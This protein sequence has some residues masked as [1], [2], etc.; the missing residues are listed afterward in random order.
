MVIDE[1]NLDLL[2][3]DMHAMLSGL[4][5]LIICT[6]FVSVIEC[7]FESIATDYPRKL[8][9]IASFDE[10]C[11]KIHVSFQVIQYTRTHS[12]SIFEL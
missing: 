8:D 9:P 2:F 10:E 5:L 6:A 12:S 4:V 3:L 7:D 1:C 11:R